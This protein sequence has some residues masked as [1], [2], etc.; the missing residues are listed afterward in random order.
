LV[1]ATDE[2]PDYNVVWVLCM[3]SD[4]TDSLCCV[5]MFHVMPHTYFVS[6]QMRSD[7]HFFEAV[8]MCGSGNW[9]YM[10]AV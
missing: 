1:A 8:S 7:R 2:H 6:A 5:G 3:S 4:L 10:Y 9:C